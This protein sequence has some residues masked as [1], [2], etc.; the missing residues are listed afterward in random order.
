[1]KR[2]ERTSSPLL[3]LFLLY[4]C[5]ATCAALIFQKF[6][7]P[8]LP[9]LH[10]GQG[11]LE[12]DSALFHAAAVDLAERIRN[13][14]W[15]AWRIYP[16]PWSGLNVAIL[17]ALYVPFGAD[18]SLIIPLN[19]MLHALSGVLIALL[20]RFVWPGDVGKYTGIVAGT[21]FVLFPS[22]LNWYGQVHKDGFAIA[23]SLLIIYGW[24]QLG[25]PGTRT[26][27][28]LHAT[29]QMLFGLLL[30]LSV[31]PYQ[32]LVLSGAL[33]C[34]MLLAALVLPWRQSTR[35]QLRSMPVQALATAI[36]VWAAWSFPHAQGADA[37]A[38]WQGSG[39][40]EW[41][42][43]W[44]S[45]YVPD[46]FERRVEVL[47]R[48]RAGFIE[49]GQ[50]AGAGSMIDVTV[51]PDSLP[52]VLSYL[53]RAIEIALFAPFPTTWFDKLSATRLVALGETLMWYLIAP[54]VLLALYYRRS[55]EIVSLLG[56]ATIIL[57]IYGFAIANVGSLY[58]VRYPYL[59]L[60]IMTGVAGW[61]E[62]LLRRERVKAKEDEHTHPASGSDNASQSGE[63]RPPLV[64]RA[65]LIGSGMV[66][67][68]LTGLGYLGFF[69]RDV[70]MARM[71]GVGT[72][73]D[74]FLVAT[75]V[76]MFFV[77][78]FS[79]PIGAAAIPSFV[80]VLQS[81]REETQRL[82]SQLTFGLGCFTVVLA[83][84]LFYA[85]P[86][87]LASVAANFPSEKAARTVYLMLWMLP[88]LALSSPIVL[89]NAVLNSLGHYG[90]PAAAQAGVAVFAIVAL[91][92]LGD[93]LGAQA[94]II[95]MF[96]GQ[97]LNLLI[98]VGLLRAHGVPLRPAVPR[99][100]THLRPFLL[101]YLPL[102]AGALF[103]N[104]SMPVNM[105][106]AATLP[107]GAVSALG[108][109]N[110]VV[111]FIAGV[112][113]TA[114]ATVILPY[115]SRILV[116][117]RVMDARRELSF[118]IAAGTLLTVPVSIALLLVAERLVELLFFG[119]QFAS[120]DVQAVAR[121]LEYS[122]LQVPFFTVNVI[123]LEFAIAARRPARVTLA[124]LVGLCLNV[125]LNLAL[126][127]RLG[128][129]GIALATT[130]SLAFATV[131]LLLLF[132]REGHIAWV[133]LI[134]ICLSWML[135]ITLAVCLH[136][137]SYAG[138][139]ATL[140]ALVF[141]V[142]DESQRL[143]FHRSPATRSP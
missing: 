132:H 8:L 88:I 137:R 143:V 29:V 127:P 34:V 98:V 19:A 66:V 79:I 141:L 57:G 4:F 130:L 124:S 94:V 61:I 42:K 41:K 32:A 136:Y 9:A 12:G 129:P 27:T 60:F 56:L 46:A 2:A 114:V 68:L 97:V 55:K 50:E 24:L 87:I 128:A 76:P 33:A 123:L 89:G 74:A 44:A 67:A 72:E 90:W 92:V 119:G 91:I 39:R 111:L 52:G 37:Y 58:R 23:G 125:T 10:A 59:F 38:S 115:F 64:G 95:G 139:I 1:M 107:E 53:P 7:L 138:V 62:L 126:M 80:A 35:K 82:V 81:S 108:L 30:V 113:G 16:T 43:S 85:G 14:G 15:N 133:D 22:A 135:F 18:P 140:L 120:H 69:A 5:Y 36:M 101:A 21:L 49:A 121:V 142:I 17:A 51:T 117:N 83:V 78:V 63:E 103:V 93:R 25:K 13:E 6:L 11:L 65:S 100:L 99:D 86:T 45:D 54:G 106:M 71:L 48:T 75:L 122:V 84:F 73:L 26:R 112:V 131:V 20:A 31:R 47:A 102:V 116:H 3:T 134:T 104:L 110:K 28:A 96:A 40:F 105:G 109:G 77:S 70:I 118:F